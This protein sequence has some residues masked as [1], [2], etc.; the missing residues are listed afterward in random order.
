MLCLLCFFVAM[1]F[2][3]YPRMISK[4]LFDISQ[5]THEIVSVLFFDCENRLHQSPGRW[6][7]ITEIL[8]DVAIAID[9]DAF[10]DQIFFD[11]IRQRF[12]LNVFSV[13]AR[14]QALRAKIWLA[15][16]LHDSL[17]DLIGMALFV[18]GVLQKL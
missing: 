4:L 16:K 14:Q 2:S 8:N 5:E 7:V 17:G 9:G 1:S 15:A 18:V 13:T 10:G 11:H 12:A 3:A 6:I